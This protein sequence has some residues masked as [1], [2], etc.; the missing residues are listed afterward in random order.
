M[1]QLL[2][3]PFVA[4]S[5]TRSEEVV[6]VG[7]VCC[8]SAALEERTEIADMIEAQTSGASYAGGLWRVG[9]LEVARRSLCG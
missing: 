3:G 1:R 8:Q 5:G 6:E 9:R 2:S 4:K 7:R